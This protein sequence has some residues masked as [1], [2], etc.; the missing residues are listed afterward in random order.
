MKVKDIKHYQQPLDQIATILINDLESEIGILELPQQLETKEKIFKA[1]K[2]LRRLTI[3]E[4]ISACWGNIDY[5][6]MGASID[7]V[8]VKEELDLNSVEVYE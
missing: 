4:T 5:G 3:D 6:C 8:S 2:R 1:L 7:D